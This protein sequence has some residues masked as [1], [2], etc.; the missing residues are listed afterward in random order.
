MRDSPEGARVIALLA[1]REGLVISGAVML[2][3]GAV[4]WVSFR[5]T[6]WSPR[7][8]L[9]GD[10]D[11][12]P[13]AFTPEGAGFATAGASGITLWDSAT[14]RLR[15]FWAQP[16]GSHSAM[17]AFSAD[18]RTFATI[19]FFGPGS[20]MAVTLRDA[21][22]GHVRWALPIGNEGAYAILFTAEAKEV[23]AIV[24]VRNANLGEVVDIDTS[25]GRELS[26]RSFT[27]ASRTGGSAVSPDGRLMAFL[28]GAAVILWNVETD[29]EQA[30]PAIASAGSTV[31]SAAFSPAGS[32]LA[33]GLSN[34]SIEIWDLPAL[35]HRAT[36]RGHKLGARSVGM[37]LSRDG[38]TIASRGQFSGADS[39][40]GAILDYAGRA[41]GARAAARQ[42]VV[43]VDVATGERL[44][45]VSSAIHPFLSSDGRLLAVRDSSFA[46]ELFDLP[47]SGLGRLPREKRAES[48]GGRP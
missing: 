35:K 13:L 8:I 9:R 40:L 25:S 39:W 6:A 18:G 11:T 46:V 30:A 44:G 33:I 34:G 32:T 27:L 10:G 16:D 21:S 28:S 41:I 42:E 43:V 5:G 15:A 47:E 29:R 12:W 26:R 4:G 36:V 48:G 19:D 17:G 37:Q 2:L 38:G 22:D 31:S 1:R 20:P 3:L 45:V 24:G 14:G 7:A 23:R